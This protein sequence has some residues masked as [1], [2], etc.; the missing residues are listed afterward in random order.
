LTSFPDRP[1]HRPKHPK[2]NRD[3][4]QT[5]MRLTARRFG[6]IASVTEKGCLNFLYRSPNLK[7]WA[8]PKSF[9]PVRRHKISRSSF[10][11]MC[12]HAI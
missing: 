8:S 2:Q 12:T 10:A 5:L 3:F 1:L 7:S 6:D 9:S 11:R 4:H